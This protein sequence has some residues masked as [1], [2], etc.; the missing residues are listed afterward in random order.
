[1]AIHSSYYSTA[2]HATGRANKS[3]SQ[4]CKSVWECIPHKN[5]N[6]FEVY[7]ALKKG[8]SILVLGMNT[9]M[10]YDCTEKEE[11]A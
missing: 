7:N 8:Q 9:R 6:F 2:S 3:C 1:M 4:Y 5:L 11:M 10:F